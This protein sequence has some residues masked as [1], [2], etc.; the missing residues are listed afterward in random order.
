MRHPSAVE[1]AR[2][3]ADHA[4]LRRRHHEGFL[5]G[6]DQECQRIEALARA[7]EARAGRPERWRARPAFAP[8]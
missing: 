4:A 6:W 5:C 1:I 7:A 8:G 2:L 3:V